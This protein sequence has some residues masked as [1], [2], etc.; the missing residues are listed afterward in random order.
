MD[1]DTFKQ[2]MK[3]FKYCG[4]RECGKPHW[5]SQGL[6]SKPSGGSDWYN[7]TKVYCNVIC[8]AQDVVYEE[9]GRICEVLF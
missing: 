4:Y 3:G 5:T 1:R 8:Y 9:T 6:F 7:P 2:Y